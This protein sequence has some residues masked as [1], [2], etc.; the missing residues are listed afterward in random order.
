M[1]V[2]ASVGVGSAAAGAAFLLRS[3]RALFVVV[4]L[5]ESLG[6]VV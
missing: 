2:E 6:V 4:G 1:A 3:I 5:P